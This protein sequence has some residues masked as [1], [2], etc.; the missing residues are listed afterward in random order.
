MSR[1]ESTS[2]S[3]PCC[4]TVGLHGAGDHCL[5]V[6][7]RRLRA[8]PHRVQERLGDPSGADA[9]GDGVVD[10][11]HQ[12]A[13]VE[14]QTLDGI[15]DPQRPSAVV[16]VLVQRGDEV[17]QLAFVARRRHRH[18]AHV[19]VEVE[20]G[21]GPPHR[22]AEPTDAGHD[23]FPQP[24]DLGDGRRDLGPEVFDVERPVEQHQRAAA[25]VE[26]RVLLDVP[27]Q[28]LGVGHPPLEAL[29]A[30]RSLLCHGGAHV[31]VPGRRSASRVGSPR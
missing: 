8:L 2:E 28:R 20:L 10:L 13:A 16:G 11:P 9:V 29:L 4:G 15:E 17:E 30:L 6:D 23:P 21:I 5:E 31:S 26:P 24:R 3:P 27:H 1:T 14:L 22:R 25:R 19:V 7:G 12:R 18:G